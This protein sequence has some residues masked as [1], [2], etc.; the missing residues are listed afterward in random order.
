MG[1]FILDCEQNNL[2]KEHYKESLGKCQTAR[3]HEKFSANRI[4]WI[5]NVLWFVVG[6]G[7]GSALK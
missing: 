4:G 1:E 5:E 7:V 6:F 2:L 3:D